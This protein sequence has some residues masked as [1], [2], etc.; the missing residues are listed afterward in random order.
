MFDY[1]QQIKEISN[2][3]TAAGA[4]M[5]DHDLM[6]ATLAGLPDEFESFIDSILL[7]L[8]STSLD[9]LHGLLLT[10]ELSMSR[11][12]KT[13]SSSNEP[14][15][16]FSAQTPPLLQTPPQPQVYAAQNQPLHNSYRYNS[17]RG[18]NSSHY[19]GSNNRGHHGNYR[20]NNYHSRGN[21]QGS[22]G[23]NS[24]GHQI[25][26]QIC[27]STSHEVIDCFDRM[28]PDVFGK[29]PPAKLAVMCA[30]Y[31]S[32]PTSSWLIDSGAT[33]HITMIYP[34]SHH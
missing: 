11:R 30:H 7:H 4:T 10:K 19:S 28:N 21:Y 1:L 32:K 16:D 12:K 2:S 25:Q 17:N 13:N 34:T 20:G 18:G 9:E 5:S 24:S 27:G 31:T 15:H 29:V 23:S 22:R 33:S 3:L 6:A 14:F 8:S 26:C